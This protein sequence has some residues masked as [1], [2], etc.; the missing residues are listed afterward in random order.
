MPG[1][2]R[3]ALLSRSLS[4]PLARAA[5]CHETAMT[6]RIRAG[7]LARRPAAP[8]RAPHT[9]YL[10]E[11]VGV[12]GHHGL[13]PFSTAGARR[14]CSQ[15]LDC[16][17]TGNSSAALALAVMA[18]ASPSACDSY[19]DLVEQAAEPECEALS[20]GQVHRTAWCCPEGRPVPI[21]RAACAVRD[22]AHRAALVPAR[23]CASGTTERWFNLPTTRVGRAQVSRICALW[24]ATSSCS[25]LHQNGGSGASSL[26]ER[27]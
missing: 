14:C 23:I 5:Q 13:T 26:P 18:A 12:V 1:G 10:I 16:P 4:G 11:P 19:R 2:G 21:R 3:R 8:R 6:Q 9:L 22:M 7:L 25:D 20:S 27:A 17:A 24:S 15:R